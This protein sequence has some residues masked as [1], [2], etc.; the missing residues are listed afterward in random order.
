MDVDGDDE[1]PK[2]KPN[3]RE[4]YGIEVDFESLEEDEREEVSIR[5]S[6]R[7]RSDNALGRPY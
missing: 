4:D 3:R 2:E 7:C 5:P 1:E 6:Y